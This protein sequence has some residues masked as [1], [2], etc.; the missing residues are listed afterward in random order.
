MR[1]L[2][3]YK[4][5]RRIKSGRNLVVLSNEKSISMLMRLMTLCIFEKE[6]DSSISCNMERELEV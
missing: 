3:G 5:V 4:P 6:T 2:P 1:Q